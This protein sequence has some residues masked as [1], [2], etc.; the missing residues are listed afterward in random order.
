MSRY[1]IANNLDSSIKMSAQSFARLAIQEED[2]VTA[3][4]KDIRKYFDAER[5]GKFEQEYTS[6][7]N[8]AGTH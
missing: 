4:L 5:F 2:K 8:A 6:A 7:L 1:A 3:T